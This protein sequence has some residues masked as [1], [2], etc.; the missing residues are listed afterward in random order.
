VRMSQDSMVQLRRQVDLTL[1]GLP[2]YVYDAHGGVSTDRR[3]INASTEV[4]D[5]MLTAALGISAGF[6]LS[7]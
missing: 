5:V 4:Q 2:P 1:V 6:E 3:C 7:W